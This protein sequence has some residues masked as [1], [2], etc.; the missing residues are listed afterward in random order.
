MKNKLV[1]T[2]LFVLLLV[3]CASAE[4][5]TVDEAVS[6]ALATYPGIK[7]AELKLSAAN[8]TVRYAYSSLWPTLSLK[9]GYGNV[10]SGPYE[11]ITGDDAPS[12]LSMSYLPDHH[13]V[14]TQTGYMV[15]MPIFVAAAWQGAE[16]ANIN[17]RMAEADLAK[18][19][20]DTA[21]STMQSF[22]Q[23]M[24][25]QRTMTLLDQRYAVAKEEYQMIR[26]KYESGIVQKTDMLRSE[27]QMRD[28]DQNRIIARKNLELARINFTNY[29]PSVNLDEVSLSVSVVPETVPSMDMAE[30]RTN[31][32]MHRPEWRSF[33]EGKKLSYENYRLSF[34]DH[35]PTFQLVGTNYW[36]KMEYPEF[37]FEQKTWNVL[38]Q[39]S[40][41]IFNGLGTFAKADSSYD[42]Y[43]AVVQ[44]ESTV[45]R[46]M[47]LELQDALLSYQQACFQLKNARVMLDLSRENFNQVKVRY[48]SGVDSNLAFIDA[49]NTLLSSEIGLAT[50]EVN[51][52]LS[53]ARLARVQGIIL[54]EAGGK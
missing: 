20:M 32:Y 21:Y 11:H 47:E 34:S 44:N 13:L 52:L 27:I 49:S 3:S 46:S 4:T 22:Y 48:M 36:N 38:L 15:A 29:V 12:Q 31:M 7:A 30:L 5:L 2:V 24:L 26:T 9:G 25:A 6:R 42:S 41:T 43:A 39:G 35:Y 50:A 40:W 8:A 14:S 51:V 19:K 23:M 53:K 1:R 17:E 16:I 45:T 18:A 33:E 37:D 10:Y 28:I 54:D